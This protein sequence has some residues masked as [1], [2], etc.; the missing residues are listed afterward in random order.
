[1]A[2]RAAREGLKVLLTNHTTHLGGILTSGLGVWDTQWEG[3]RAPIYD[4]V[5]QSIFDHY[6]TTYGSES[7]Q[8]REALPGKTG[9]TNGKFEP[10]VIE[11]ILSALVAR[12]KNITVLPGYYPVEAKREGTSLRTVTFRE[13]DGG[14]TTRITSTVFADCTYEGDLLPLAK[15]HYRIGRE[16]RSELNEP[17]AGVIFMRPSATPPSP[18]IAALAEPHARLKLRPFPGFQEVLPVS[19]GAAD[20]NVQAFNY[21]TMLSS[22]PARRLP[23]EKPADYDKEALKKLEFSSL[24]APIPN[25]KLGWN[26]PQLVGPHNS[27]I[28]ADWPARRRVM[29]QHWQATLGLLYFMQNDPSVPETQRT[30]WRNYGIARDEFVDNGHRP[31]EFYVREARRLSGRY[32]FSEHDATLAPGLRRAPVHRDSIAVTEWYMDAHACTTARV[33]GSL[34]EG[35][36]MLHQ[37]TFPGQLPYRTLFAPDLDNLIVPICL[38][39]TH[40][41]WGTVRLEPTWMTI[42]EAAAFATLQ[43]I[44]RNQP[45]ANID[46]DALLRTLATK[47][48]MISFFNDV[49][50]SANEPWIPAAQY[51]GTKGFFAEYDVRPSAALTRAVAEAWAEGYA[52]LR[53]NQ[54]DGMALMRR[55]TEAE[56]SESPAISGGEFSKLAK[57][58]APSSATLTRAEALQALWASSF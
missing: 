12:E 17:H 21:R 54:H 3:K 11:N 58:K 8:Y 38:S 27:Y 55:V 56:Q 7:R 41:A 23:V 52:K 57:I 40:V 14:K 2:V 33:P 15:V 13:F 46:P 25:S 18:E 35:K 20:K 48:V 5:R 31:Y 50:V 6:R 42:G 30:E 1:M 49:D 53:G 39:A 28:E 34:D 29:D 26:R 22:D 32:V 9:H 44:R 37:E 45:P 51:F 10:R 24:V 43:A 16:S 4:E 19:S 47:H 36:M